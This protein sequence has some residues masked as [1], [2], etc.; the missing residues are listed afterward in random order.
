MLHVSCTQLLCY[1]VIKYFTSWIQFTCENCVKLGI[2]EYQTLV[3][4]V[5]Q[6]GGNGQQTGDGA[7]VIAI[8]ELRPNIKLLNRTINNENKDN[9]RQLY[10]DMLHTPQQPNQQADTNQ[11]MTKTRQV[12]HPGT[13]YADIDGKVN[14]NQHTVFIKPKDLMTPANNME[15][16]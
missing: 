4:C 14:L 5:E 9:R 15:I 13:S 2:E 1:T 10:P 11:A 6:N 16:I 7:L 8:T 3:D 12:K